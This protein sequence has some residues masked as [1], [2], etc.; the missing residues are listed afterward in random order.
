MVSALVV[1]LFAVVFQVGLALHTRNVLV[2]LAAEGARYGANA[3]VD[4]AAAVEARTREALAG[5]F[6]PAYAGRAVI[7]PLLGGPVVEVRIR[8]PLPLPFVPGAPIDLTVSGHAFEE[9]R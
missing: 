1:V 9:A 3:D 4:S 8:A 2:S 7:T 6:N 5:A